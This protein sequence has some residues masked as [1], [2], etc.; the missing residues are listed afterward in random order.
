M[1]AIA[2]MAAQ[3]ISPSGAAKAAPVARRISRRPPPLVQ[4]LDGSTIS[5]P[6][7]QAELRE[8]VLSVLRQHGA[9]KIVDI[10]A[11]LS[12]SFFVADNA[13]GQASE[14]AGALRALYKTGAVTRTDT[15]PYEWTAATASEQKSTGDQQ[16]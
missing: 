11:L 15:M 5:V 3:A 4:R 2:W 13:R 6:A 10:R 1:D 16:K 9:R 8:G 12:T 7:A 14:V